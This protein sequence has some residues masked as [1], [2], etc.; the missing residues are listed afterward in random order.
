MVQYFVY[1]KGFGALFPQAKVFANKTFRE[2]LADTKGLKDVSKQL[3]LDQ[4]VHVPF[5]FFPAYYMIKESILGRC[6]EIS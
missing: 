2:K 5:F 4:L 3:G 6:F 1:V